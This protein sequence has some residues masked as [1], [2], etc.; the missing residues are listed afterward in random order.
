[1][2]PLLF[3]SFSLCSEEFPFETDVSRLLDIIVHSLYSNRDVF[4]REVISNASDALDK[5]NYL[6]VMDKTV[7]GSSK[8]LEIRIKTDEKAKTL[9]IHDTGIGMTK[10]DLIAN[11]GTIAKSGT[12]NFVE[13]YLKKNQDGNSPDTLIGK[14]W[15]GFYSVYLVADKVTVTS[16]HPEDDQHTWVSDANGSFSIISDDYEDLI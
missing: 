2:V 6:G 9:E 16:K 15:V 1:M 3:A 11:L 12:S 4:L 13:E 7:L 10:A 5:I 14:F 8:D